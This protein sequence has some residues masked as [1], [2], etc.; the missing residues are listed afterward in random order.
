MNERAGR[1]SVILELGSALERNIAQRTVEMGSGG[2]QGRP[3]EIE[4]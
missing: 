1:I 4:I 3:I 2:R